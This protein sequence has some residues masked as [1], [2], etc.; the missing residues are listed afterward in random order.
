MKRNAYEHS[1]LKYQ[2]LD[3]QSKGVKEV[4]WK[5]NPE[6]VE[7]IQQ[8]FRF[9]VIPH[10]YEVRTKT[11]YN[12]KNAENILKEIHYSCKRGKKSIIMR[13]NSKEQKLLDEFEIRYRPYKYRVI[14]K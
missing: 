7:F 3:R 4:I 1:K 10:L 14:I 8:K 5:L 11:F 9:Q 13:L 6:Q 12:V 2:L